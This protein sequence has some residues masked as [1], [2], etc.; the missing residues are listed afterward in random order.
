MVV[1]CIVFESNFTPY[2]ESRH[3]F[4][5]SVAV[6]MNS[7]YSSSIE[8]FGNTLCLFVVLGIISYLVPEKGNKMIFEDVL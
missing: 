3:S 7:S 1:G 2:M 8:L 5:E 4:T 6:S